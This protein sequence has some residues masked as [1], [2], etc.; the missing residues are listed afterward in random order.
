MRK[1]KH[2]WTIP[3]SYHLEGSCVLSPRA[4]SAEVVQINPRKTAKDL[5]KKLEET[6]NYLLSR[7]K[8]SPI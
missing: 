5:R 2:H 1:Y 8:M 3:L 4:K 6:G 7:T